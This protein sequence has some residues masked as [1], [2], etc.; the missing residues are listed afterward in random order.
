M[1][2]RASAII[3]GS[4]TT[5]LATPAPSGSQSTHADRGSGL[6]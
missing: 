3:D 6:P 4:T 5:R 1:N 2:A